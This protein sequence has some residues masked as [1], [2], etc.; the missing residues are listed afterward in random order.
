MRFQARIPRFFASTVE[1]G[2]EP[3]RPVLDGSDVVV[4]NRWGLPAHSVAIVGRPAVWVG[5]DVR[6]PQV[7]LGFAT[8]PAVRLRWEQ[9]FG[10]HLYLAVT[11]EDPSK[12]MIIEA[13]PLKPSGTGNLVPFAYPEDDFAAR[14]IVDFAP[15][16]IKPPHGLTPEFF[17]ELVRTTQ[18]EYDGD[19]RYLAIEM[20]FLRVGRDSN[21]YA[22]GVLLACSVDPRAIPKPKNELRWE[23]TGYPGAEDPVHRANFGAYLGAPTMLGDDAV[24]VAYHN[25]DGSVRLVVVGGRPGGTA[26]LPDGTV[27]DLDELGRIAFAPADARAHLLPSTHTHPPDQVANRRHFPPDP[28]PAGA[29]ITLVVDGH[30]VALRPGSEYRG[31]I[32]ARHDALGLAKLRTLEGSDVVL[33]LSELGIELRD[34]KRVD[35]LLHV[36]N[37]L[38]VGLHSDRHPKLVAHGKASFDDRFAM[39]QPHVPRPINVAGAVALAAAATFVAL[40]WWRGRTA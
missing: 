2:P 34:P 14:G 5:L 27:V 15:V 30:S 3:S 6:T 28:Q 9:D 37:E 31:T 24:D 23:M 1:G 33:P 8:L 21:S 22:V 7:P 26:R 18:R 16:I 38:T 19:Q 11:G 20:P 36:G 10:G 17:T 4:E 13:G 25:A 29:E 12:T 35:A 32:V 40:A 39:H